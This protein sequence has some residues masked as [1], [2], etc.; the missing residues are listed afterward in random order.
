MYWCSI[1]FFSR[2]GYLVFPP[3]WSWRIVR[4]WLAVTSAV[5]ATISII[6]TR[7]SCEIEWKISSYKMWKDFVDLWKGTE[8]L[9]TV[10]KIQENGKFTKLIWFFLIKHCFLMAIKLTNIKKIHLIVSC[11]S[12]TPLWSIEHPPNFSFHG[13][14]VSVSLS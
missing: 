7:I 5:I 4:V 13:D 14:C 8:F 6:A 12:F 10:W 2:T 11:L 1:C 3:I 9:S